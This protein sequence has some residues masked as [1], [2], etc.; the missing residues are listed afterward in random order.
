M[1]ELRTVWK[2]ASW[3]DNRF[4]SF[5]QRSLLNYSSFFLEWIFL[6]VGIAACCSAFRRPLSTRE[7]APLLIP[8]LYFVINY[9]FILT[10][11]E[12]NWGRY[13]LPTVIAS[14]LLVAVG[15]YLVTTRAY[16]YLGRLHPSL[17]SQK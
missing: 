7:I 5:H 6:I 1:R 9:A 16:G 3:N 2:S 4:A 14:K 11:M 15:I 12:L 10:F 17:T 13:Y 8:F